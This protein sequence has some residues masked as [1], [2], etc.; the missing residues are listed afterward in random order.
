MPPDELEAPALASF[1]GRDASPEG[2]GA[3]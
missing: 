2:F 1:E 3:K